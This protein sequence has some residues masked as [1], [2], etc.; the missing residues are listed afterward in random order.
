MNFADFSFRDHSIEEDEGV[1][2]STGAWYRKIPSGEPSPR[3]AGSFV[4]IWI[5]KQWTRQVNMPGRLVALHK[6]EINRREFALGIVDPPRVLA[7]RNTE[8]KEPRLPFLGQVV[9]KIQQRW[10][11]SDPDLAL[12]LGLRATDELVTFLYS[13]GDQRTRDQEDRVANIFRISEA[14]A[15]ILDDP[16]EEKEWLRESNSCFNGTE[17]LNILLRGGLEDLI[18]VRRSLEHLAGR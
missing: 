1:L 6:T 9:R 17:P 15:S 12:I 4:Q 14:L 18:D 7:W 13:L 11:L 16:D 3:N 8:E 5:T 2:S 10:G